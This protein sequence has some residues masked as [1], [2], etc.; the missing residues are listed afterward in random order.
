MTFL[1]LMYREGRG[2]ARNPERAIAWY[3]R[4]VETRKQRDGP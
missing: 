3:E 4:A 1:G 2:V